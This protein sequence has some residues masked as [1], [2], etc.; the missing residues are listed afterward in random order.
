M[1]PRIEELMEC[2]HGGSRVRGVMDFSVN[3]NPYGPPDFIFDVLKAGMNEI[4]NYPDVESGLLKTL[5]AHKF[6]CTESRVLVGAGVSELIQLLAIGFVKKRAVIPAYTYGEYERSVRMMGGEVK[7]IEMPDLELKP[8]LISEA[9]QPG[10]VVFLCN[11]NN[12][13]GQYIPEDGLSLLIDEAER[14]D[15]LLVLDEA[16]VDFVNDAFPSH[17]Y[18]SSTE[19]LLI[20]R[21]LTKSFTIPG[22]RVGYALGSEPVIS[23]LRRLKAPWSVSVLAQRIGEAV[24]GAAGDKFIEDTRRKI[25][26]S[27]RMVEGELGIHSDANFYIFDTGRAASEVRAELLSHGLAVRDCTSFGLPSHIRFSVQKDDENE[28]LMDM[29]MDLCS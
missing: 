2:E 19:N 17:S 25:S 7:R 29:L 14:I 22:V 28:I 5:I 12:P 27:K 13:T 23:I 18:L 20:L 21:S 11:P 4:K 10:D 15:A 26:M 6:G 16:Y 1:K 24:L 8:E 9:M 3:L